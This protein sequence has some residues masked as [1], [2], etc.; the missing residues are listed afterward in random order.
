M[1]Q[2]EADG[3]ARGGDVRQEERRRGRAALGRQDGRA[4]LFEREGHGLLRGDGPEAQQTD[5]ALGRR[6][7]GKGALVADLHADGEA[8]LHRLEGFV[9]DD[10]A[11]LAAE[12]EIL[13]PG[14]FLGAEQQIGG[15]AGQGMGDGV[16]HAE[17]QFILLQS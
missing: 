14:L 17:E 12:F 2:R 3:H 8:H 13:L 6:H 4:D 5:A 16:Q 9:G 11:D 7:T 1:F 10:L 15:R